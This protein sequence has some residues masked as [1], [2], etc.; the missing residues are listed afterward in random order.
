VFKFDRELFVSKVYE[1][2]LRGYLKSI[3]GNKRQEQ[4]QHFNMFTREEQDKI[5]KRIEREL[6]EHAKN[7][8]KECKA[9]ILGDRDCAQTFIKSMKMT[10]VGGFTRE[11]R[12]EYRGIVMDNIMRVL[13]VMNLLLKNTNIELNETA[14]MHAEVLSQEI[15][16]IQ[17]KNGKITPEAMGAVQGLWEDKQFVKGLLDNDLSI[18]DSSS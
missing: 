9:L 12:E 2:A 18:P 6:K 3:A 14:K 17:T 1:K 15:G 7:L 8:S 10:H 4:Q 13:E 16:K 5:H 11:E